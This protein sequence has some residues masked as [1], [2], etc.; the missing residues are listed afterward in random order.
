MTAILMEPGR[1]VPLASMVGRGNVWPDDRCPRQSDMP[2]PGDVPGLLTGT[3]ISTETGWRAVEDI[4]AGERVL[5]FDDGLQRVETVAHLPGRTHG[6]CGPASV[7][8][9]KGA[10]GNRAPLC[11]LPGQRMLIETGLAERLVGDAFVLIRAQALVGYKGIRGATGPTGGLTVS[12]GFARSQL[13]FAE[14]AA[15]LYCHAPK[16]G[17]GSVAVLVDPD[18]RSYTLVSP[19]REAQLANW[20][21][22]GEH[23]GIHIPTQHW[24]MAQAARPRLVS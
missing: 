5:T 1:R 7:S 12:L 21:R 8:I 3:R 16:H 18:T 23:G 24:G 10:L 17:T 4:R 13:V 20:L 11:V 15:L 6:V 2:F 19:Q 22:R 9:P 14:G